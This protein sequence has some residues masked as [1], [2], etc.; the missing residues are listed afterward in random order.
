MCIADQ[1]VGARLAINRLREDCR[2]LV[3]NCGIFRTTEAMRAIADDSDDG[4]KPPRQRVFRESIAAADRRSI[5][6]LAEIDEAMPSNRAAAARADVAVKKTGMGDNMHVFAP[7]PG[8]PPTKIVDPRIH[9]KRSSGDI[10]I[11]RARNQPPGVHQPRGRARLLSSAPIRTGAPACVGCGRA[12]GRY[13]K[14]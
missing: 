5:P 8:R 6:L 11:Y 12:Q 2:A 9:S 1:L 14:P 10:T 4:P 7:R 13:G 3:D